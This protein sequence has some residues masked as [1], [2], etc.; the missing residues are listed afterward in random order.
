MEIID[1]VKNIL[2]TPK[3][4][5]P[6]IERENDPHLK[7]LTTY[8]LLLA[9]IPAIAIFIGDGLI[10]YSVFGFRVGSIS[11]GIKQAINTLPW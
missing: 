3:T 5:W 6:T 8:V 9:A 7:V 4:E 11:L 2:V 10:G 1:R